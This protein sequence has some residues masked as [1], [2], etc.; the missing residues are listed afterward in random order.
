MHCVQ[1]G[2]KTPLYTCALQ[3]SKIIST[4]KRTATRLAGN[5][6]PLAELSRW[7]VEC[8]D[9]CN[10]L[11]DVSTAWPLGATGS[12]WFLKTCIASSRRSSIRLYSNSSI[13]FLHAEI[14]HQTSL[15]VFGDCRISTHADPTSKRRANLIGMRVT[16][17]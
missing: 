11:N 3:V 10:C 4:D 1:C 2:L 12:A 5:V 16:K 9:G 13:S 14:Q 15:S 6:R 7:S 8:E 17:A